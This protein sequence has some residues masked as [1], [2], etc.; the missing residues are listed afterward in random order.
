MIS[1]LFSKY[2]ITEN[3][4]VIGDG[5]ITYLTQN[6]INITKKIFKK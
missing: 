6:E 2:V 5:L 3:R 4:G 1:A